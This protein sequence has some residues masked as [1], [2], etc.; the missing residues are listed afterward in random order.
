LEKLA[1]RT[2]E[3]DEK[4]IRKAGRDT[5]KT[6][7]VFASFY[8][9]G[10]DSVAKRTE[11]PYDLVQ[12]LLREFWET[13]AGVHDWQKRQRRQ[14][15]QFGGVY[16]LTNRFRH[17]VLPGNECLNTPI[18]GT[19]TDLVIDA[20]NE[21][22]ALSVQEDDP[23][24]APRIN[25]H[26]DLTFILP[27]NDDRLEYYFKRIGESMTKVRYD[28][29]NVPLMVEYKVGYNWA[30]LEEIHNYTGDYVR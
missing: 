8:G 23:F 25:V 1:Y 30:D 19:G 20:Q 15:E 27:D 13:F 7:F 5:I 10:P 18:Q 6:D 24:L 2:N 9:S 29:Q 12:D 14:F 4:K 11:I 3:T 17:D 26:D 22:Y 28:F 16:T 21:L